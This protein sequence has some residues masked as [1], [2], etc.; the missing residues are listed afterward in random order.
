MKIISPIR[1]VAIA[2][3]FFFCPLQMQVCL[4]VEQKQD[5]FEFVDTVP[6]KGTAIKTIL[7]KA[8][9][10]DVVINSEKKKAKI[11]VDISKNVLYKY[12]SNGEPEIAYLIASGKKSTPTDTGLRII[13]HIE[14]YPY[15]SAPRAT[16]RRKNPK[17]YGP[18]IIILNKLD[19]K[20]GLQSSCGEFIHGN[21]DSTSIGKYASQGCM[22]MDNGVIKELASQVKRGDIVNTT[23]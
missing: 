9:S 19:P 7:N 20:T 6:A 12:D 11:V 15:R 21:N 5:S 1:K 10:A 18:K 22:R 16:K 3:T 4:P 14:T 23:K 17:A 8:P 13:S 2:S